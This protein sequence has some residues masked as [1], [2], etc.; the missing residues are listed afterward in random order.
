MQCGYG[1][2]GT[3]QCGYG[4][5]CMIGRGYFTNYISAMSTTAQSILA[6]AILWDNHRCLP[7]E[8]TTEWLDQM[9]KSSRFT[10]LSLNIGDAKIPLDTQI[11][12]AAH[13]RGW[14]ENHSDR[15]LMAKTTD[16]VRRAQGE[17]KTA[18]AFDVEGAHSL[19]GQI[20]LVPLLYDIGVRWMLI[21]YNEGNWAGGGCHDEPD[22][23]LTGAGR[24]LIAEM[25]RVGI[26][27]C[28]SH[29]GY[30]TAREVLDASS[31]PVI[32]SHSNAKALHDHPRNIPDDLIIACAAG[33]GVVGIT[34]LSIFLSEEKDLVEPFVRHIDHMVNLV[35]PS[36]VG[37][38]LDYVY[39]QDE[40][41]QLLTTQTDTWPAGYGYGPGIR[42]VAPEQVTDIVDR[43]LQLGYA[44]SDIA[45]I[46][47]G[48]FL[49]IADE[50]WQPA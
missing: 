33:G 43:L 34:G 29:T 17:E 11:R 5:V 28:C 46:L 23:G 12:M 22:L 44:E 47:G 32:F 24:E 19:D 9:A 21:A 35:G 45:L 42:F 48:N 14:V 8:L 30:R 16:D 15:F 39:N 13:F 18:I 26:V 6:D 7:H 2:V 3:A 37:V 4:A 38:S 49:R 36:H 1:N 20:S 25:D 27:K 10:F 50:V 40:M 31:R 41:N